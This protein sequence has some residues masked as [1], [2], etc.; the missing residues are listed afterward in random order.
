M[1]GVRRRDGE[2]AESDAVQHGVAATRARRLVRGAAARL[3]QQLFLPVRDRPALCD[4]ES[5]RPL[6]CGTKSG[7]G[8]V[9]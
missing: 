6:A 4:G 9:G 7:G 3:L 8:G 1:R 5:R 2:E